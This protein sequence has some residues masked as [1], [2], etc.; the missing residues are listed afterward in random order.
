MKRFNQFTE[1]VTAGD[2]KAQAEGKKAARK[3][4]KYD[5]N[6]Y[7]KGSSRHLQWAK[8]H[9]SARAGKLGIREEAAL[10]ENYHVIDKKT[11]KKVNKEPMS[12][13][14]ALDHYDSIGGNAKGYAVVKHGD[15]RIKEEVEDLEEKRKYK[16]T[17]GNKERMVNK[18]ELNTYQQM[19]WKLEEALKKD[20]DDPCWKDYV[21]LG[22]K[23]KNGKEVPNCVPK[24]EVEIEENWATKAMAG[25]SPLKKKYQAPK[26]GEE[27]R[28]S[29]MKKKMYGSMMGGL[30]KEEAELEE[31]MKDKPYEKQIGMGDSRSEKEIRD[32]ISGL[33]DATLK[34]WAS[35]STGR[36]GSKV[37]KLQ[38]K[39]VAAEM[40][41]RGLRESVELDEAKGK[42]VK[43]MRV[44]HIHSDRKG[45]VI[46][47][48]DRA[49]G[50]VEVEWDN[51]QTTVSAGKYLEPFKESVELD[52][53]SFTIPKSKAGME[54]KSRKAKM[55]QDQHKEQDPK[56]AKT[57]ARN[58]VD[59]DKAAAKAAKKGVK[60]RD[61]GKD[62]W[63][64]RNGVKRGKLPEEF[65]TE[66]WDLVADYLNENN[67]AYDQLQEMSVEQ[68]DEIIGKAIGGAFKVGAK[69][70]VGAARLAKK[71]AKKA[72]YNKQG[73]VRGSQAAKNDAAKAQ[74]E[75]LKQKRKELV[76]KRLQQR[77]SKQ[78]KTSVEREK[79]KL[80]ATKARANK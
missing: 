62:N 30:K 69:A 41:K 34:K 48:G 49:G 65:T 70:A 37:A 21:Q 71:G 57:H 58:M 32:Q 51:G 14:R 50:R 13:G 22:T 27:D 45:T 53:V 8:G 6:P 4:E 23:K 46:K 7:E 33:S 38:D 19:G 76:Q 80:A 18:Q 2:L 35:K 77:K 52:E 67:I 59:M 75:K 36:F 42:L 20:S 74:I 24:E 54:Y 3:G 43:N 72:V 25:K 60:M 28:A 73:N 79:N 40:K 10:E 78:L 1:A 11:G 56:H 9:N 29:R 68:L 39:L 63:K 55:R 15:K 66:Q 12:M 47:G 16:V 26:D 31:K 17:K 5:S 44:K 61:Y 64:V